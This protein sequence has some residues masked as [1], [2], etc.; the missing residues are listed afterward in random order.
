MTS[1]ALDDLDLRILQVMQAH[2]S[3]TNVELAARVFASAPTTMRRVRR[4]RETGVIA[5]EIAVLDAEKVG[6]ALT[7]I[8]EVTLDRQTAEDYAAFESQVCAE[9]AVTQCYRVSPGPDFVVMVALRD[10]AA[11]DAFARRLF[12]G[13]SNVRN[14]RTFFS[15]HCARFAANPPVT[16]DRTANAS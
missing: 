1:I 13:A 6:H 14:V 15:T 16:A 10:M 9:P 3:L 11:Y 8:I 4:L 5:R 12:R 2:A 7:A